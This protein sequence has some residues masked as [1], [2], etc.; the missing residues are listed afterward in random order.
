MRSRARVVFALASLLLPAGVGLVG[1]VLA[2]QGG[3]RGT[4]LAYALG[5]ALLCLRPTLRPAASMNWE[6]TRSFFPV[7]QTLAYLNHAGVAPISTR[8]AEALAR[9]AT[10]ATHK[11]ASD[12]ARSY[13]A[14]IER[15]R[16]R[17]AELI[18]AHRDEIA[19]VKNTSE[20]LG[21]VAAG[22]D[23]QRGDRVVVCDLEYPSNVYAWWSLRSRGVETVMLR[24]RDGALPL[25]SVEEALAHPRTRLLALSSVE[26]GSGARNDLPGAR[27]PVPGARRALLR[28]RHPEPRLPASRRRR[29]VTS[30]SWRRMDTS[31]C[32]RSRAAASSSAAAR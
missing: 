14:E 9:Y 28:R 15:V 3:P 27:A 31:G 10:E 20:G 19:F 29:G 12:Y 7:T 18:G 16:G 4:A 11:G 13:D 24:G 21:L 25:E 2:L 6:R 26:F 8:V 32:S 17:A 22:L 23:W 1:V 5:G 30:I